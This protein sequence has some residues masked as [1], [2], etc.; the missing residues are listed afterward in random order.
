MNKSKQNNDN[1]NKKKRTIPTEIPI[2]W[3][4]I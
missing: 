3:V 2:I 4:N 1:S